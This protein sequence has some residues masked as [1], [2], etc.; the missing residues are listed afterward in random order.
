M[1]RFW[2]FGFTA[3]LTSLSQALPEGN[4]HSKCRCLPS[5]PCWP[6]MDKWQ[7]LNESVHGHLSQVSPIGAACHEPTYNE[8]QCTNLLS[9][10]MHDSSYRAANPGASQWANWEA[11][12][13]HNE[14]CYVD[15]DTSVKCQQGRVSLYSVAVES[16]DEIAAALKFATKHNIRLVVKNTGHD[17]SG[18]SMAANSLQIHTRKMK[19]IEFSDEFVAHGAPKDASP[20][21]KAITIGAG[22]QLVDLYKFCHEKNVSVVAG[23]SSTVGA[24]GGYIQGGGHSVISPWKGM[25]SDN[26]IQFSVVTA[27]GN[28]VYA[29]EY[30]N[31]D[32]FWALRGGGGGT[33]GIVTTV[34][35][36]AH[37]NPPLTYFSM[38]IARP[39]ADAGYWKLVENLYTHLP[40]LN[41]VGTSLSSVM[42]PH[43]VIP[44]PADGTPEQPRALVVLKGFVVGPETDG[45]RAALSAL[46]DDF[47]NT[48]SNATTSSPTNL[49]FNVTTFPSIT[50]FYTTVLTGSDF[51]GAAT[52]VGSR[53]V[54]RNFIA[55]PDGPAAV[56]QALSKIQL[57]QDE[58]V[59]GNMVSGGAVAA[60]S[61]LDTALHPAWRQALSHIMIVR[62]WATASPFS[63]QRAIHE[64]LTNVQVPILKG[65][66]LPGEE[67]GSYLNE[68]DS[69][70]PDFQKSFWGDNYSRLY[71]I[72]RKWDPHGVFVVRKG[73]GSENWDDKGLCRLK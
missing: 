27:D 11:W 65:L 68:A 22:V 38:D 23:F 37:E 20:S 5:Q 13:S 29:N 2:L 40:A 73:V 39:V 15:G 41:D 18:R 26:V 45:L 33:F 54:S 17:F 59:S 66:V 34:T 28:H 47:R 44:S 56:A 58:A 67:M 35:F 32:L 12:E 62:G 63:E 19:D 50:K 4:C 3:I 31:S 71:N 70:E 49:R 51:G 55:S 43:T 6:S 48:S 69:E 61:N 53:L 46:E 8:A 9:G 7:A 25:A 42:Y 30:E 36:Q 1:A 57:A 64:E 16:V 14:T 72:K 52:V 24:A 10:L 21:G 60:N